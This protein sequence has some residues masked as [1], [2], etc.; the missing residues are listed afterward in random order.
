M[1]SSTFFSNLIPDLARQFVG[2]ARIRFQQLEKRDRVAV[3]ALATFLVLLFTYFVILNPVNEYYQDSKVA[4][5][6][7]LSLI[8]YM[9]SSEK[10]AREMSTG[11]V[12]RASGQSLLT[13]VSR[14]AQLMGIKPNRLQPE[15]SDAVSVWFDS[16]SFSDLM[17][18]LVQVQAKQGMIVQQISI[19]R[20][21][22]AGMVRARIVLR[23]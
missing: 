5:D 9:R 6:R 18:L 22:Q 7:Q 21:E 1:A 15:G 3:Q 19:D 12:V 4:R 11:S 10:R 2:Q 16:V 23:T 13:E 17:K 20:D 14:A 8:Q